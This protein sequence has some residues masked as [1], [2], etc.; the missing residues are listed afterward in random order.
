MYAGERR[1]RTAGA[2]EPDSLAALGQHGRKIGERAPCALPHALVGLEPVG[3]LERLLA[4]T[5]GQRN[6]APRRAP[7]GPNARGP[8]FLVDQNQLGRPATDVEDER[9]TVA[10]LEQLVAAKDCQPSLFSGLDD[11]EHD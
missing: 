8:L 2:E 10:R 7:P 4:L 3:A 9:R 5:L 1:H 6:D 11:I